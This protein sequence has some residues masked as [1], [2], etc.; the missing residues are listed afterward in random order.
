M[1][2]SQLEELGKQFCHS[3]VALFYIEIQPDN[4]LSRMNGHQ[5]SQHH[6]ALKME[7]QSLVFFK[8][9]ASNVSAAFKYPS[10]F[11]AIICFS[12]YEKRYKTTSKLST[13]KFIYCLAGLASSFFGAAGAAAFFLEPKKAWKLEAVTS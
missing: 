8:F 6:V 4:V 10:C 13:Y 11:N 3:L 9:T 5:R 1:Q 2:W 7:M 12:I